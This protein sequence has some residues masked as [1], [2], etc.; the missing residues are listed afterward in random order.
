VEQVAVEKK[1]IKGE[2]V[3][4]KKMAPKVLHTMKNKMKK[5]EV[6]PWV[7]TKVV[8]EDG[9]CTFEQTGKNLKKQYWFRCLTCSMEVGEGIEI[10]M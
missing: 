4:G 5:I 2:K 7:F 10:A 6:N 9:R 1:L 8:K 3:H